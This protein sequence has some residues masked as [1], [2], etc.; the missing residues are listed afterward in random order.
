MN[1]QQFYGCL[2][3]IA[4]HQAHIPL[5]QELLTKQ[6][7]LP[8]PRFKWRLSGSPDL[9]ELSEQESLQAESLSLYKAT[10]KRDSNASINK[11][12]LFIEEKGEASTDSEIEQN[13]AS[14]CVVRNHLYWYHI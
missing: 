8:L 12:S 9:I 5:N 6:V 14:E 11:N 4:A 3:L 10:C 7:D 2:K 13:D 1:R